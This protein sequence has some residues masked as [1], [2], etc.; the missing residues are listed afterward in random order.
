RRQ[1]T[2]AGVESLL[3]RNLPAA[4]PKVEVDTKSASP[5]ELLAAG[6]L[7]S[8]IEILENKIRI[9]PQDF[10]TWLKLAEAHAAYCR[11]FLRASKIID[12]IAANPAFSSEQIRLAKAKLKE[13]RTVVAS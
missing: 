1:K 7:S 8:A 2:E 3:V 11:D 9:Q 5:D 13:W 4:A 6:H 10:D 12:R